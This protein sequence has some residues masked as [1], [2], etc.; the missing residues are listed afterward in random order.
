MQWH[1][2]RI[3]KFRTQS[4]RQGVNHA[5][6]L[7]AAARPDLV[8]QRIAVDQPTRK[9]RDVWYFFIKFHDSD[10]DVLNPASINDSLIGSIR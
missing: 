1:P 4:L 2:P 10:V 6:G 9:P 3:A 5:V 8:D 7:H